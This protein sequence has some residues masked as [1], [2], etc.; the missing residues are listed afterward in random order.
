MIL[1]PGI[2]TLVEPIQFQRRGTYDMIYESE[3]EIPPDSVKPSWLTMDMRFV[4]NFRV[5][6]KEI[7][8]PFPSY[9][10][11]RESIEAVDDEFTGG[12]PEFKFLKNIF[13]KLKKYKF[14]SSDYICRSDWPCNGRIHV[15]ERIITGQ[16]IEWIGSQRYHYLTLKQF[17]SINFNKY[18]D[19]VD[20]DND[21]HYRINMDYLGI[22]ILGNKSDDYDK[23]NKRITPIMKR[24]HNQ[25]IEQILRTDIVGFAA[26]YLHKTARQR[27]KDEIEDLHRRGI[28]YNYKHFNY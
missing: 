13:P 5:G 28:Y 1:Y 20:R 4:F 10:I 16:I 2:I 7:T 14:P 8:V 21:D 3:K 22:I 24:H 19:T 26:N 23:N 25:K 6:Y 12:S 15:D 27:R 11:F 18:F 9:Y 17:C